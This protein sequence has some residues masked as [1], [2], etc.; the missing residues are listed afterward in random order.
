MSS[1]VVSSFGVGGAEGRQPCVVGVEGVGSVMA[2]VRFVE[3]FQCILA[4]LHGLHL[5]YWA[6]KI[7][8]PIMILTRKRGMSK[9]HTPVNG[10]LGDSD[11]F[12]EGVA[13][14]DE[15]GDV[16]AFV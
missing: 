8:V 15:A 10:L 1:S 13:T 11:H 16:E 4:G 12:F 6:H 7:L 2:S 5:L 9:A 3:T 14:A